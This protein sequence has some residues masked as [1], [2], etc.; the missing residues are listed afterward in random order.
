MNSQGEYI[1][2]EEGINATFY[3][4]DSSKKTGIYRRDEIGKKRKVNG[5][6]LTEAQTLI[7]ETELV[8]VEENSAKSLKFIYETNGEEYEKVVDWSTLSTLKTNN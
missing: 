3:I 5:Y 2:D 7:I 6:Y 1:S 4:G 8:N